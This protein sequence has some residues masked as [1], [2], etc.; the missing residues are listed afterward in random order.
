M[1][2]RSV[3]SIKSK[4]L[5]KSLCMLLGCL[6]ITLTP[7]AVAADP[8]ELQTPA[9]VIYLSDNLDEK[10]KLGW[11]IDTKGR[12]FSEQ[13]HAHSCK[14]RGG[15]VQFSHNKETGQIVSAT[16]EGKCATLLLPAAAGV[17]LGLFD[18]SPDTTHQVF[19]Y[20]EDS[21]EFRP[22]DDNTLCLVVGET[23]RAAGPFMSR[24]LE[25]AACDSTEVLYKQWRLKE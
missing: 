21:S 6:G 25:L 18:C 24:N 3:L 19:T 20:H 9:P 22:Q 16:F 13:L 14:P 10:D 12:G 15:D 8:P 17:S 4:R 5:S 7:L 2:Q 1:N 11:C 23:S